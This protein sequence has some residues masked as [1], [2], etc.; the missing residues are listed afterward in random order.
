MSSNLSKRTTFHRF[1]R[2]VERSMSNLSFRALVYQSPK[3]L[4]HIFQLLGLKAPA[5]IHFRSLV[6]ADPLL[7]INRADIYRPQTSSYKY[8]IT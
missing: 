8:V 1:D 3:G 5:C 4:I 2:N 6:R 7:I